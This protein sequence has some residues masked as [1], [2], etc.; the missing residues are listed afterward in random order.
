MA[1]SVGFVAPAARLANA[2]DTKLGG[3]LADAVSCSSVVKAFGAEMRED[4]RVAKVVAK[5]R[6]RTR[7]TWVRGTIT[8]RHR[9]PHCL[10][11]RIAVIGFALL[12]WSRGQATPATSPSC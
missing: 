10:P 8:A 12:L 9:A 6:G 1:L 5:W 3:S 2:W 11:S 7:R 4:T